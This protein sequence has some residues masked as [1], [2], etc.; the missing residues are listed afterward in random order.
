METTLTALLTLFKTEKDGKSGPGK[1]YYF[2][3]PNNFL[4]LL[5]TK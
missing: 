4:L 2:F 3:L 1:C 5:I